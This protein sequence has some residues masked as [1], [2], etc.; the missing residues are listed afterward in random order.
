MCTGETIMKDDY[1]KMYLHLFNAVTDALE[2]L[3]EENRA[4][5]LLRT[6]QMVCEELYIQQGEE[7]GK[8][9]HLVK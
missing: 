8:I 4:A 2:L 1:K 7:Q 9:I 5:Q 3:P 6:A